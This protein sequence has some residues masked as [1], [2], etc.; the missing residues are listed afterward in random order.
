V[1]Q[2]S[3]RIQ[4]WLSRHT[5]TLLPF[6]VIVKLFQNQRPVKH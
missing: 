1:M 5:H 3:R 6:T 4:S 2:S